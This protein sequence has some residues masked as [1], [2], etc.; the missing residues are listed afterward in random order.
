MSDHRW[1]SDTVER[2]YREIYCYCRRHVNTDDAAYELTQTVF[3]RLCE[4][5]QTVERANV[6]AWLYRVAK[7]VCA[8]HYREVYREKQWSTD[9]PVDQCGDVFTRTDAALSQVEFS[10]ALS[11]LLKTLT[12]EERQLFLDRFDRGLSYD[13]LADQHKTSSATIR[14][15]YSRLNQKLVKYIKLF[16][17]F[18]GLLK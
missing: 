13:A 6:R 1:L 8:D 15:R 9:M 18:S 10:D 11:E 12:E 7:N 5:Y 17:V 14:K 4:R 2:Y 16:F 3:L